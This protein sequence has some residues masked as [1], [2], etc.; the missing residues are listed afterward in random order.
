VEASRIDIMSDFPN[1]SSAVIRHLA[2]V[3]KML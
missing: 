1:H 3:D 2:T